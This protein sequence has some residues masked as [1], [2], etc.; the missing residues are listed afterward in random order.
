M[1]N[2]PSTSRGQGDRRERSDKI[3][4]QKTLD[5]LKQ[6]ESAKA[7]IYA[8]PGEDD[9]LVTNVGEK[10]ERRHDYDFNLCKDYVHSAM[11]DEHYSMIGGHVDD[12]VKAK[13]R[14]GEYVDF[15][16]LIARGPFSR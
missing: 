2:A 14:N 16:K 10:G 4:E 15:A 7:R 5:M 6:A 1:N 13:I 3:A 11:V 8:M 12:S 9:L